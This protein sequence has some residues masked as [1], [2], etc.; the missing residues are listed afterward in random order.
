MIYNKEI[1]D[2]QGLEVPTTWDELIAVCEALEGAGITPF[3]GTFADSWTIGQGWYDYTV[4]GMIDTVG[5][6]ESSLNR[7]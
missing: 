1:F 3:Y 4:G 2:Q 5:L 6:T 7:I